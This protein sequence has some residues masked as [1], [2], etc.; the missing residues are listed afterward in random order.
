MTTHAGSEE[1][2]ALVGDLA[3]ELR[4]LRLS[5]VGDAWYMQHSDFLDRAKEFAACVDSAVLLSDRRAF[6]QAFALLRA[7]LEQW[8]VDVVALVGDRF[9]QLWRNAT[10]ETLDDAVD[11]WTRGELPSVIEEPRLVGRKKPEL[12]VVRRGY[13]SDDRAMVLHPMYFEAANYDPFYGPPGEQPEFADWLD[14]SHSRDHAEQQRQT[15]HAMF[16]WRPLVESLVLNGLV[17]DRHRLHVSVHYRYLSAFV[18]SHHAAQRLLG[19]PPPSFGGGPPEPHAIEELALMY[20]VQLSA[21]YLDA[22][23]GMTERPP[24]VQLENRDRVKER[25][26]LGL[27]RTAHLWFLTDEP[28]LWDRGQEL[29]TR[30]AEAREFRPSPTATADAMAIPPDEVRY[31]RNPL[32]RLR[33]MHH[34]SVEG[35]TGFRYV[36]PWA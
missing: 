33:R 12:H 29:L 11:R 10:Q 25:V 2:R 27:G 36:S 6:A 35:T 32:D 31:Y 3:D 34:G 9:V 20:A 19:S 30:A 26:A 8:A 21:R 23:V 28:H 16:T 13:A 14:L 4:S 1:L 24:R 22:F 5:A 17:A 15:Y 18:H 7:A